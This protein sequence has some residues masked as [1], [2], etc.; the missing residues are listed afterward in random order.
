MQQKQQSSLPLVFVKL[1]RIIRILHFQ[2]NRKLLEY[3]SSEKTDKVNY[4]WFLRNEQAKLP[5]YKLNQP[6]KKVPL[7]NINKKQCL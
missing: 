1:F 7:V 4:L 2:R 3:E 5:T 6:Q